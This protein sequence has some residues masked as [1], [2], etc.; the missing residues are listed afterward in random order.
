MTFSIFDLRN[1][2]LYQSSCLLAIRWHL[3]TSLSHPTPLFPRLV[4]LLLHRRM[5]LYLS[6]HFD[7]IHLDHSYSF[8]ILRSVSFILVL[9][10]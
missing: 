7:L 9:S 6:S 2:G 8:F 5:V 1:S 3:F 10:I 4:G